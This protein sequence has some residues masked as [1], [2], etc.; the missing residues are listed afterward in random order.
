MLLR[1]RMPIDS[2]G[3]L[4]NRRKRHLK[5]CRSPEFYRVF[6][7]KLNG[8]TSPFG[9]MS[10]RCAY[11]ECAGHRAALTRGATRRNRHREQCPS[12]FNNARSLAVSTFTTL[13]E[14]IPAFVTSRTCA[15]LFDQSA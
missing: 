12:A 2:A 11:G 5:F 4:C 1:L 13:A 14:I 10:R 8:Q 15:G 6:W 9:A 3:L 7:F